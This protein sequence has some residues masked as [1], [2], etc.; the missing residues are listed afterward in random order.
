MKMYFTQ[1][2]LLIFFKFSRHIKPASASYTVNSF[3]MSRSGQK[4]VLHN[5]KGQQM[6]FNSKATFCLQCCCS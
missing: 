2:I 5:M 1:R 6:L 4:Q 3:C